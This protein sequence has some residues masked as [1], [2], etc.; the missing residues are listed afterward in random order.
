[1]TPRAPPGQGY[2]F[3]LLSALLSAVAAV[4]T[5]WVMKSNSD[6]LY[7]QNCLLYGFG[8]AFNGAGLVLKGAE[9]GL[10]LGA[11]SPVTMFEGES[12]GK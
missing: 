5:E 6:S 8:V 12:L 1:M 7:W 2:L 11:L 3:G 9:G 4:Y 10:N